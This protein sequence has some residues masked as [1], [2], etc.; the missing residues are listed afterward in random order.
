MLKDYITIINERLIDIDGV[1]IPCLNPAFKEDREDYFAFEV[2]FEDGFHYLAWLYYD[3][4][5]TTNCKENCWD[6]NACTHRLPDPMYFWI[7]DDPNEPEAPG[8]GW[9]CYV[10]LKD[11]VDS[12]LKCYNATRFNIPLPL[13]P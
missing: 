11:C 9:N 6:W 2:R 7:M 8:Q 5:W 10:A 12:F 4:D 13:I 1:L 3:P